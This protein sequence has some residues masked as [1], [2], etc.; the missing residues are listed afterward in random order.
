MYLRCNVMKMANGLLSL[1][2][3]FI[4][5][6]RSKD[7]LVFLKRLYLSQRLFMKKSFCVK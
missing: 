2:I 4:L 6:M 7:M 5:T 3:C 1:K